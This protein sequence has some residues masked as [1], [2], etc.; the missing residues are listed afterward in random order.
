MATPKK[1]EGEKGTRALVIGMVVFV[2]LVGVIFSIT[3]KI[4]AAKVNIPSSVSKADGYGIVFNATKKPVIDVWE[5][6][7]CPIC[8]RFEGINGNYLNSVVRSGKAKVVYHVMSFIGPESVL[9]AAASACAADE[10]KF[11]EMHTILYQN[12]SATENS[13]TWTN[14]TL[15]L[16]GAGAGI[17][18][19]NYVNC[20]NNGKYVNWTKNIENDASAHKVNATP[21]I[22]VNGKEINRQTQY[23]D[24][25]A[26]KA[27]L[28]AGGVK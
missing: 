8:Q 26:F 1:N 19:K 14:P 17:T 6:F 23:M 12:Q 4:S 13:G 3:T 24:A 18:S 21:T 5:D 7:Q 2:V 10:G 9:A 11:L 27:A 20:V 16:M 25:A 22:F 15:I 28:V